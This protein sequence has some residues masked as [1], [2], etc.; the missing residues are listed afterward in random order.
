[1]ADADCLLM[2][3]ELVTGAERKLLLGEFNDTARPIDREKTLFTLFSEQASRTP[4]RIAVEHNGTRVSYRELADR[5][6]KLSA[7]L[8]SKGAGAGSRVALYMSRG[9]T[10]LLA[11]V[12]TMGAGAAYIPIEV[13]YPKNRVKEILTDSEADIVIVDNGNAAGLVEIQADITTLREVVCIDD[14]DQWPVDAFAIPQMAG[15]DDIAYI[16]YTSG[17]TGKPKGAMVHQLGMLNHMCALIGELRL[18][19]D[20]AIAQTASCSFDISVWQFLCALLIGGRTCIIDKEKLMDAGGLLKELQEREITVAEMVP[21][22]LRSLVDEASQAAGKGLPRLRWMIPTAEQISVALVKKWYRCYPSVP[23]VNAYGPAEASDDVTLYVIGNEVQEGRIIPIGKPIQNIRIYIVDKN[24]KLCPVGVRGE[25]CIAGV[26]VGKGYWKNAAT[27]SRVFVENPFLAEEA[28]DY[29][30]LYR[31]GDMG[32]YRQDG[33]IVF[34]GRGDDQVKI[35]GHRIELGEIESHLLQHQ[36][37][38]EVAMLVREKEGSKHLVAYYVADTPVEENSL[39]NYLSGRLPDHMVPSFYVQVDRMPL[40]VNGKLDKKSLPEPMQ[41]RLTSSREEAATEQERLLVGI[42]SKVL[43]E[44]NVGV[45]DNFFSAGGDS[46]KSTQIISALRAAGYEASVKD[47]FIYQTIRELAPRLKNTGIVERPSADPSGHYQA[48]PGS[49]RLS[50]EELDMLQTKYA[51]EDVYPLSPMQEG[52]L[53]HSLYEEQGQEYFEQVSCRIE[54]R[55]DPGAVEQTMNTILSRYDVLR[56]VFVHEGY[57]RALQVV[58]KERK[59]DFIYQDYREACRQQEASEVTESYRQ[60]DRSRRFDL[61]KDALMRLTVLQLGEEEYELIWSYHHI[62]MDGWCMGIILSDFKELYRAHL[63]GVRPLL[64]PARPYGEYIGWLQ[65]RRHEEM[66]AYWQGYLAGYEQPAPIGSLAGKRTDQP[67]DLRVEELVIGQAHTR[68]LQRLSVQYGVTINTI[69]QAAW[70]ILLSKYTNIQDVVFGAVVSGRPAEIAGIESMVGLFIN[71]VPVRVH[72]TEEDTVAELLVRLQEAALAGEPHHYHPLS[73]I[74]SSSEAGRGLFDHTLV[75][76]NYPIADI[77]RDVDEST[78]GFRFA[79]VQVYIQTTYHL[80]V[81]VTPGEESRVNFYY[82]ASVFDRG[83]IQRLAAHFTRVLEQVAGNSRMAVRDIEVVTAEERHRL[84]Y[85]YND[86]AIAYPRNSTVVDLF[87]QCAEAFP[88]RTALL[89]KGSQLTYK[90]LHERSNQLAHYLQARGVGPGTVVGLM[91]ER[92]MELIIGLLGILKAG[93][94]YLPM[95]PGTPEKRTRH[96]LGESRALL[97]LTDV[98]GE[99]INTCPTAGITSQVLPESM[100]Y[101]L[102]TS[103]STGRPKGVMITHGT[104]ANYINWACSQYVRGAAAAFPLFTSVAFDLTVTSL[105]CPLVTGN[106]L[107]I[108]EDDDNV[109]L[110]ERIIEDDRVAVIKLTPSHLKIIRD[111]LAVLRAPKKHLQRFIVGGEELTT[112]LA[113]DIYELFDENVE[114]INEYG[115]TEATVGCMIH[116]FRPEETT[117]AVPIGVP[118]ANVCIYL[119][120]RHLQLTATGAVGEIYISGAGVAQGYVGNEELTKERFLEDPFVPGMRMYRTGDLARWLPDG[121]LEF[122]GRADEQV[123]IRGFR[124]EPG[125][126]ANCLRMHEGVKDAVVLVW[127]REESRYLTAYYVAETAEA[128]ETAEGSE[129]AAPGAQ[130][131]IEADSLRHF[132]AA[133]LPDHMIPTF[134]VQIGGMPL[135]VNGK[136]DKKALPEPGFTGGPAYVAPTTKEERVLI[137]IWEKVLGREKI[138]ISDNFFSVGGDSIKSLQ[139]VSRL[140]AAGYEASVKEIF[141]YPTIRELAAR[142]KRIGLAADQSIV[143]GESRLTPIQQL[144]FEGA[145]VSKHH[146]NQSVLL[147][148]AQGI[149]AGLAEQIAEALQEH[150]DALRMVFVR[151]AGRVFM[152]NR[153]TDMKVSVQEYDLTQSGNDHIELLLR[154]ND[155]QAGIGLVEGPLMKLG[156]FHLRDGSRLLIVIHHL[157]VDGVSWRVLLEDIE[158]LYRQLSAGSAVSLPQ[159]TAPFLSWSSHLSAYR[160]SPSFARGRAYWS[161]RIGKQEPGV[162]RD[163]PEGVNIAG[164]SRL[165]TVRLSGLSTQRLLTEAH[166]PFGTRVTDLLLCGFLLSL[167]RQYG[168]SVVQVDMENHGR[169]EIV[170]GVDMSR[171]VGWFASICPVLLESTAEELPQLIKEVK[172]ALRRVPNNG[173][174]YLLLNYTDEEGQ[175]TGTGRSRIVFNYLGQFDAD[176]INKSFTIAVEPTGDEVARSSRNEYEWELLGMVKGGELELSLRFSGAQY[177]PETIRTLMGHYRSALESIIDFCCSYGKTELTPSDL[178]Y[179]D[180]PVTQ[181]DDLQRQYQIEDIYPLSPMQEGMLFHSLLEPAADHYFVQLVCRLNGTVDIGSVE[182]ALNDIIARY[183][184]LRTIFLYK[185]YERPLQLVLKERVI[186]IDYID[187]REEAMV[188]PADEIVHDY[189]LQDRTRKF[190]LSGGELMRLTVLRLTDNEYRLIWSF[191]HILMD[192]WCMGIIIQEFGKLYAGNRT[193]TPILLPPVQAYF[194][195]IEWLEG[196]DRDSSA[197]YWREYLEGFETVASLP[198]RELPSSDDL[199]FKQQVRQMVITASQTRRLRKISSENRVTINTVLQ[200]GWGI[201]LA[202]YNNASDVLFG[203]VVSGRPA[204]IPGVEDMVGLFINTIPV[205]LQYREGDTAADLLQQVQSKAFESEPYHYHPLSGIQSLHRAG[206]ELFTHILVFENYPVGEAIKDR[207]GDDRPHAFTITGAEVFE[208][209]NYDLSVIIVP[210]EE[211]IIRFY[212]NANKYTAD[213]IGMIA[214]HLNRV[215][216]QI[217]SDIQVKI[218]DIEI[219]T[220]EEKHQLLYTFNDTIFPYPQQE[221]VISLFEKQAASYPDSIAIEYGGKRIS[222]R[223][224]NNKANS[225]ARLIRGKIPE[226]GNH[227]VGMLFHPCAEMI[228][229]MLGI[230]KSGGAYVPLSPDATLVRNQ[231]IL[232]DCGAGLLLVQEGLL[233]EQRVVVPLTKDIESLI[234]EENDVWDMPFETVPGTVVSKDLL[235]IIYTSGTTGTPKGVAV[236]NR[237]IINML[238]FY[239]HLYQ[240]SMGMN[241]S[242]IANI[243]FDA[244]A[245]EIWPALTHGGCLCIAPLHIRPDPGLIKDWLMER[246][247]EIAFL[248]TAL[249]PYIIENEWSKKE[250]ALRVINVA[251]D[252]LH[253]SSSKELP[254]KLYN[255]YGPTEDSIWTTFTEIQSSAVSTHYS[256]GK[257]IANKRIYILDKTHKPQP[258]GIAGELCISGDG[259][260]RG[261]VNNESLTHERFVDDPFFDGGRMYKTGDLAR[262]LPTGDIEFLGRVDNQVKIRGYRVEPGEVESL[263]ARYPLIREVVVAVKERMG[264]K[265]LV[266]YY[267]SDEQVETA[268]LRDYL[269]VYLPDYMMPAFFLE[270]PSLP[271]TANGKIDRKALPDPEVTRTK[272]YV[273]ASNDIEEK[274][275]AIWADVLHTDIDKIGINDNFF[276]VGGHSISLMTL[277]SKVNEAFGCTISV[278]SMFKLPTIVSIENFIINGDPHVQK[279]ASRIGEDMDEASATLQLFKDNILD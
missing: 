162:P 158:T 133:M 219:V 214:V 128:S 141:L 60:R 14:L 18:G 212:Y 55:L 176:I 276:D 271:V 22:V 241:F 203:S 207:S 181:L 144:F 45:T 13:E 72:Y 246:R 147:Q 3:M 151:E 182:N 23:L 77:I 173:I 263:L 103:G 62:L 53:F 204:E 175:M 187:I 6:T 251:G 198:A 68:S 70:G 88:D 95:E 170:A 160:Q 106:T 97:L 118:A 267:T 98:G 196:R 37:I 143:T 177:K 232:T 255:L 26:G 239:K 194:R 154:C 79:G 114:I 80:S 36:D 178:T 99:E 43:G 275:L 19:E 87:V 56:T 134:Y 25:I 163:H 32:F 272:D 4:N 93:G 278:A 140:Y 249:A 153:G 149:S 119:L 256:I 184:I 111:S 33:N 1:M 210:G 82:N 89:Y 258:V 101:I 174:D 74:Q 222:Y 75:F 5:A 161:K 58:L 90:E 29:R 131:E 136:L 112:A 129:G 191:H 206:R 16:I 104:L 221:T 242:H 139:I 253:Y 193:G 7:Y 156:V 205:R 237:G 35:R 109:R 8:I 78:M 274:L 165:E 94:A 227:A 137:V 50:S 200:V 54:G 21:S 261:Y 130:A 195:Y 257:P 57:E 83:V 226:K 218:G 266:A 202:K 245:F 169:E 238:Y 252:R 34:T 171:T 132:L 157:V 135:T 110:I 127:E 164:E 100:A 265:F 96:M 105:F 15:T 229:C 121:N 31:T 73:A 166:Q 183:A 236:M 108:Y 17:T 264:E 85:S 148:F 243:S 201:L 180:L 116:R 217:I 269:R 215:V 138:G 51:L 209:A 234:V 125:E 235:Y 65:Q 146:Y 145:V 122:A 228:A 244:S 248:P 240:V 225:I 262:W 24:M 188:K 155:L 247:I 9:N 52:M 260:A 254:F 40:T 64:A 38:K 123:K 117:A 142:L 63:T 59:I 273:T 39:R 172:E 279:L 186:S 27:T 86:K 92:S 124:I 216:E 91:M 84:L 66:A 81:V 76:E 20:D 46:I 270:L 2:E 67:Y 150:H 28:A 120:D 231:Y 11:I 268:M 152:Q 220:G 190:D 185:G 107:V 102:Y 10:M 197:N 159:K 199:P 12:G 179:K 48:A 113:R 233:S 30:K 230:L 69:L 115:P 41:R 126:I 61:D 71:T 224:L 208:Q 167:R 192:G 211:L 168:M 213:T 49:G 223:Q 44:V 250:H 259:L 189:Q 47:I 42:W 277:N